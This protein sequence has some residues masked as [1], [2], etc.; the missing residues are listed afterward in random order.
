MKKSLQNRIQEHLK[1]E[2]EHPVDKELLDK[3][4]ELAARE[5]DYFNLE[6]ERRNT[7]NDF[8][9][10]IRG[11]FLSE[12]LAGDYGSEIIMDT[13][14]VLCFEVGYRLKEWEVNNER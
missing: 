14:I 3:L 2:K 13:I 11:M 8:F 1:H 6:P 4:R 7:F 5:T 12:L 10:E 9:R